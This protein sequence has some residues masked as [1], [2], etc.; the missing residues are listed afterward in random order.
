M[1]LIFGLF[2]ISLS[3]SSFAN[4]QVTCTDVGS[5]NT[6]IKVI[7]NK[8]TV[9]LSNGSILDLNI[10]VK[11]I[12]IDNDQVE[13]IKTQSGEIIRASD[14]TSNGQINFRAET[15]VDGGGS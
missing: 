3:L 2:I 14:L 9:K 1:K 10:D 13:A 6:C 8:S 7:Q 5:L 12:I 4:I 11:D 15:G